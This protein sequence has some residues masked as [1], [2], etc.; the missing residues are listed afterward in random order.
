MRLLVTFEYPHSTWIPLIVFRDF[1][2]WFEI[3][4]DEHEISYQN[5]DPLKRMNP[6]G[7]NSPQIMVIKNLDNGKYIIVSY[8]DRAIELTWNGNGW[9]DEKRVD[10]ITS[11]GIFSDLDF[12]PFSYCCYSSEFEFLSKNKRKDFKDKIISDLH[13][14]GFLYHE[15]KLMQQ[16]KPEL[17]S[18]QRKSTEDYFNELNS[19]KICLSLNGA[20]EICNR[21]LEILSCGSVLI[22]PELS[23]RF[24]NPLI[25]N[26][27]YVSVEKVKDPKLQLDLI[28]D[29]YNNIKNDDNYLNEVAYNGLKWFEENGSILSNVELL[30]NIVDI[31]KLI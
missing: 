29:K 10:L 20:G 15:R 17:F 8:W 28:I 14:R 26:Y 24:H 23:Q 12:T 18:E 11:S 19:N 9:D 13:F 21:D 7:P 30:K 25:P 6:S 5:T 2:K 31:N 22:R 1:F 3:N 16:Y 27:H 4:Y